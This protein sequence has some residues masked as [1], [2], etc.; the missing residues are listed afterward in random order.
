VHTQTIEVRFGVMVNGRVAEV[1][2]AAV[3]AILALDEAHG[4]LV[5]ARVVAVPLPSERWNHLLDQF[6]SK[7]GAPKTAP[8]GPLAEVGEHADRFAR[9]LFVA[10]AA[11]LAA[12]ANDLEDRISL[13]TDDRQH[14]EIRERLDNIADRVGNTADALIGRVDD[15]TWQE[16]SDNVV[17]SGSGTAHLDETRHLARP[18]QMHAVSRTA[19]PAAA[20]SVG[21]VITIF[22]DNLRRNASLTIAIM[23]AATLL[24]G[25]GLL[26]GATW[27]TQALQP[28]LRRQ[29]EERRKLN[30]EWA[31]IRTTRH[32]QGECPR[33]ASPLSEQDWHFAPT[34]MDE[35]EC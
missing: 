3:H 11:F 20:G 16:F 12:E 18:S 29:A 26:L 21:V 22:V 1:K 31:A 4:H 17:P 7:A 14:E 25:L 19:W 27:T 15:G 6:E 33:C 24:V 32:Q 13:L 34:A 5:N 28:R 10:A 23:V 35:M 8:G 2:A 30:E 9:D